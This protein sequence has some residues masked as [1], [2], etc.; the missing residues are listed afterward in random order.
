MLEWISSI[1]CIIAIIS[2]KKE[3]ESGAIDPVCCY[4]IVDFHKIFLPPVF[5]SLTLTDNASYYY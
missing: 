5:K 3:K 2:Y 4:K 1:R